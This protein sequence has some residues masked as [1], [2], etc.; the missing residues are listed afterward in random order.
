MLRRIHQGRAAHAGTRREDGRS[1]IRELGHVVQ[2]LE[3]MNDL[4]RSITVN[5]GVVRGGRPNLVSEPRLCASAHA[6][7][8][9]G[10]CRR[11]GA[12]DS[13]HQRAHRGRQ[14]ES[15]RRIEP[16]PYEKTSAGA[17]LY[18]QAKKLAAELGFEPL[19]PFSGSGSERNF[20]APH[21]AILEGLGVDGKGAHTH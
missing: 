9:H 2:T 18:A 1:A 20:T 15:I 10:P 7:Q 13:R 16:S 8:D 4:M 14:N 11:A 3:E 6:R 19:E 5:V 17:A 12:Q 21:T